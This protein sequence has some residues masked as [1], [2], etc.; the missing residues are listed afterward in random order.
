VAAPAGRAT[1]RADGAVPGSIAVHEPTVQ[2]E[3]LAGRFHP[4]MHRKIIHR[5][6]HSFPLVSSAV[7]SPKATHSFFLG[8]DD[9]FRP[10]EL[11]PQASVVAIELLDLPR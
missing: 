6:H 2:S 3:R 8:L 9:Q 5:A 4:H 11:A 7:G 1:P 10:L